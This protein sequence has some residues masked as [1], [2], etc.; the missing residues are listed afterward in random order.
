FGL[1]QGTAGTIS[2]SAYGHYFGRRHL[3]AI[4]GFAN[5]MFVASSAFGPLIYGAGFTLLG[6]YSP[7]IFAT[8]TVPVGLGVVA[9]FRGRRK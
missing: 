4:K 9:L 8:A 1:L 7:A 3:G 2:G 5:T 6:S